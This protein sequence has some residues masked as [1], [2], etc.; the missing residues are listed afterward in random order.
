M[1]ENEK[2]LTVWQE[3]ELS[4][5]WQNFFDPKFD[6][7]SPLEIIGMDLKI[8]NNNKGILILCELNDN[9]NKEHVDLQKLFGIKLAQELRLI[10]VIIPILFTSFLSRK[11]I[12]SNKPER[13]IINSIG[14]DF[15][16]LP[17]EPQEFINQLEK[18]KLLSDLE[19]Y[20]IQN[21]YCRKEGMIREL[22]HRLSNIKYFELENKSSDDVQLMF[23]NSIQQI[24][25]IYNDNPTD[26]I[27]NFNNRYSEITEKNISDAISEIGRY[28]ERLITEYSPSIDFQPLEK[29]RNW[30]L[31]WIDDEAEE[32]HKLISYL[33]ESNIEV[34][35]CTSVSKAWQR[36]ADDWNNEN[37]IHVIV[38]D[39]RLY[40][41]TEEGKVHQ[42]VQGYTFLKQI[43]ELGKMI[44][45]IALSAL[46]RKFLL[47]SFKHYNV[48]AQIYS[49]RDY[50]EDDNTLKLLCTELIELGDENES[51]ISRL[52]RITS[53]NWKFFEPFYIA[54]RNSLKCKEIEK[55]ISEK[56]KIYCEGLIHNEYKFELSGYTVAL[57][58]D[59][60]TK[61]AKEK[62]KVENN[63]NKK[64]G[65][66]YDVN[67]KNTVF[68]NPSNQ[69]YFTE[70]I[71]KMICRRIAIW[72]TQYKPTYTLK[73]VHRILKGN[74]Y[75]G[76][77]TDLAAKNQVNTNLALSLSEFPW[78][79][80]VEEK[81]WM[82]NEMKVVE[83]NRFEQQ[84]ELLL[85]FSSDKIIKWLEKN[86]SFSALLIETTPNTFS[87]IRKLLNQVVVKIH[88][89]R[90]YID[91]LLNIVS[92][93]KTEITKAISRDSYKTE[94]ISLFNKYLHLLANKLKRIK[95][96]P[97]NEEVTD[98]EWEKLKTRITNKAI[99]KLYL[100]D[101]KQ[102]MESVAWLF[103]YELRGKKIMYSN[104]EIYLTELQKEF[105][106]QKFTNPKEIGF[107]DLRAIK[108]NN[109]EDSE[110][111]TS[112]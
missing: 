98:V 70:F 83:I 45:L 42:S 24:C 15:I 94:T 86:P 84:E 71:N 22:T 72:Y 107:D 66:K 44:K 89:H 87:R 80:T 33:K 32:N 36:L 41:Q 27:I 10:G 74:K 62:K 81:T 47:H 108:K 48:S 56:A 95:N 63:G 67:E 14:H 29:K 35:L 99:S 34:L 85:S 38:A 82:I 28:G 2:I 16:R 76:N 91:S 25:G 4:I 103:F 97:A 52:P 55:F 20:D 39:Y 26:F 1:N 102:T 3:G 100:I 30:K 58:V 104:D 8:V 90:E 109:E 105:N 54:H 65:K 64:G 73:D 60:P 61:E 57:G 96:L 11:Q 112:D 5:K 31:L 93:C 19:L 17:A 12:Y 78:N 77:E 106:K 110:D 69:K 50:L 21:S 79:M 40:Q 9:E 13:E 75:T 7:R 43:S 18:I 51:A 46:P 37:R 101:D 68:K 88:E 53:E 23:N 59:K 111:N 49:K 6:F 92:S